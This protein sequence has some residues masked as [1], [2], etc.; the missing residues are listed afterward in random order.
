MITASWDRAANLFDAEKGE[1]INTLTG[2]VWQC[3]YIIY[4]MYR[5]VTVPDF[6]L[7]HK[8]FETSPTG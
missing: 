8:P 2:T 7:P 1:V 4:N 5:Y 3:V 6:Y